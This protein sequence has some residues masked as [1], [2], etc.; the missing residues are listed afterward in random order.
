[1]AFSPNVSDRTKSEMCALL[2]MTNAELAGKISGGAG[3]HWAEQ[4]D[5]FRL[6]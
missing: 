4:K 5:N 6:Y 3:H 1:M 2:G